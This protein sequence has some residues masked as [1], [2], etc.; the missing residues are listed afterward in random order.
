[1]EWSSLPISKGGLSPTNGS[2]IR[3]H[4]RKVLFLKSTWKNVRSS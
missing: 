3:H 2:A 1:M 4:L